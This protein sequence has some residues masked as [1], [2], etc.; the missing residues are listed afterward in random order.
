[1]ALPHILP[2]LFRGAASVLAD[3]QPDGSM[4]GFAQRLF[5]ATEFP[6]SSERDFS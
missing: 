1:M 2:N 4:S 5:W 3:D 6:D